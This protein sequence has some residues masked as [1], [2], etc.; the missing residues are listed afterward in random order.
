M[1]MLVPVTRV[2]EI[3]AM[4]ERRRVNVQ[5]ERGSP[6]TSTRELLYNASILFTRE[7]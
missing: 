4:Y 2:N 1:R 5:V 6:F 3:E 7:R